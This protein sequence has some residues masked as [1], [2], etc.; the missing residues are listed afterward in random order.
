MRKQLA[1]MLAVVA[2]TGA[3]REAERDTGSLD[4]DRAGA[5]TIIESE[6]VKDTTIVTADTSIDVDTVK[7]TDNIDDTNEARKN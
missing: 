3:C 6:T 7:K 4:N 2:L 5:D 1:V